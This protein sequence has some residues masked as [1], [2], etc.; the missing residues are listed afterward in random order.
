MMDRM[1]GAKKSSSKKLK[2]CSHTYSWCAERGGRISQVVPLPSTS[3]SADN[4]GL[5]A[6]QSR[7]NDNRP[8]KC[9]YNKYY[10]KRTWFQ[11]SKIFSFNSLDCV[12]L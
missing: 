12:L 1:T 11:F 6:D 9:L 4:G 3:K 8:K 2:H 10:K 7:S 5:I